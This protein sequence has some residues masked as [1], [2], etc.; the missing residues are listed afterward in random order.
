MAWFNALLAAVALGLGLLHLVRLAT[1]RRDGRSIVGEASHAAMG[2]GMSAMFSPFG[3][4]VPAAVWLGIFGLSAAWFA[5]SA[6]RT[7][8]AADDAGHHVVCGVSMLFMLSVGMRSTEGM[9]M[10]SGEHA[11]H[12]MG[13]GAGFAGWTSLVAI[14]LAGYFAW[15]V[16]RCGDRFAAARR[17]RTPE[18]ALAGASPMVDMS[19]CAAHSGTAV[20]E[21]RL[22]AIRTPHAAAVAHLVMA[23]SM[24]VMLLGMI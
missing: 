15:H 8:L 6:L 17:A 21:G 22:A 20:V 24:A 10:S 23:A 9:D 19:S 13:G 16:M 4:P 5:A 18:P 7:G 1:A 12:H 2:L 11:G 14:V 3:D